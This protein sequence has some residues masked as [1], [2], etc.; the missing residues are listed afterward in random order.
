ML[1]SENIILVNSSPDIF[2]FTCLSFSKIG[3]LFCLYYP[4]KDFIA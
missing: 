1:S 4:K 3:Q 2:S